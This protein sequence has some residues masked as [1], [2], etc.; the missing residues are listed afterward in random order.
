MSVKVVRTEIFLVRINRSEVNI[1]S[2][3]K[4]STMKEHE[5]KHTLRMG[6]SSFFSQEFIALL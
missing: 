5:M 2:V 3:M 6:Y 1:Q 4:I